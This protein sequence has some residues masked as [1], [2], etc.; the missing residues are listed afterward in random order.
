M[1]ASRLWR[2]SWSRSSTAQREDR[3][4]LIFNSYGSRRGNHGVMMRATLANF[5][6]R[7]QLALGTEGGVTLH[8]PDLEQMSIY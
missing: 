1:T 3:G 6:L 8:L 5:R 4:R 2:R 7:N